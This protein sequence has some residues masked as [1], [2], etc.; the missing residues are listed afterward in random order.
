[1]GGGSQ[2]GTNTLTRVDVSP[3]RLVVWLTTDDRKM[4]GTHTVMAKRGK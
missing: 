4:I 1:V 2:P 3:D